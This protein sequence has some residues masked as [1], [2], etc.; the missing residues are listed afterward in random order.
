[1]L[2]MHR[3][4]CYL[5]RYGDRVGT[6]VSSDKKLHEEDAMEF[7]VDSTYRHIREHDFLSLGKCSMKKIYCTCGSIVDVDGD[8]FKM[9]MNL[10]KSVECCRCRNERIGREIDSLNNH[11]LGISEEDSGILYL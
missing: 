7:E 5:R 3:P 9:R 4:K 2:D 6:V 1:M 8:Y 10:G 11:F